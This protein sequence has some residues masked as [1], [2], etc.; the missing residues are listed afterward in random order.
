MVYRPG[1]VEVRVTGR[2]IVATILDGIVLGLLYQLSSAVFGGDYKSDLDF[3]RLT[4]KAG[5][6]WLVVTLLYYVLL[7]GLFGRTVGKL[8]TGIRVID[9]KTGRTQGIFTALTRTLLRIID[10][11][12]GYPLGWA[13]RR[14]KNPALLDRNVLILLAKQN[15]RCALCQDLLLHAD[16]EPTSPTEWEQW[17]RVTRKAITKHHVSALADKATPDGIRLVHSHCQR[18]ATGARK[19]PAPLYA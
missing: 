1:G 11:I 16:H 3:T 17:H 5:L 10:S 4:S 19:Q 8:V 7:E 15:G 14:G 2:R 9:A 6:G 12:G 18:R 13:R